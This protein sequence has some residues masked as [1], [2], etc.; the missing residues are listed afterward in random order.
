[1]YE[2]AAFIARCSSTPPLKI[3]WMYKQ[4]SGVDIS[5]AEKF[6]LA[7]YYT[8]FNQD[9][10]T[11]GSGESCR[12]WKIEHEV[13]LD[14]LKIT[15]QNKLFGEMYGRE[16]IPSN[17]VGQIQMENQVKRVLSYAKQQGLISNYRIK[18]SAIQNSTYSTNFTC[19]LTHSILGV[20]K[21]TGT[22][23]H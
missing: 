22:I 5:N 4:L 23:T 12:G 18:G 9:Q 15:L 16:K 7:N 3:Q 21:I 2:E 13:G 10:G 8:N 20:D 17:T 1:M 14:W 11:Y 6:P 19:D